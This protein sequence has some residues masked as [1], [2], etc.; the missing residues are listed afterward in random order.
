MEDFFREWL[1][2]TIETTSFQNVVKEGIEI[3]QDLKKK[4]NVKA[5]STTKE[6]ERLV[7]IVLLLDEKIQQQ[8]QAMS[9]MQEKI[10][11]LEKEI[12]VTRIEVAQTKIAAREQTS[13]KR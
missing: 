9:L 13:K 2:K 8:S 10:E 11:E 1:K 5:N 4:H 7:N 6:I 3:H 12:I